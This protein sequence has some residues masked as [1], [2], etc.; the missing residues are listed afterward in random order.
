MTSSFQISR[1]FKFHSCLYLFSFFCRF[2]STAS[3]ERWVKGPSLKS[4]NAKDSR[5][6]DIWRVRR[7]SNVMRGERIG[8]VCDVIFF[9][10]GYNDIQ[11]VNWQYWVFLF[12][13]S[14]FSYV[15]NLASKMEVF[16]PL[17]HPHRNIPTFQARLWKHNR[18]PRTGQGVSVLVLSSEVKRM[19]TMH[20]WYWILLRFQKLDILMSYIDN[21]RIQISNCTFLVIIADPVF[22]SRE[23]VDALREIQS[24]KKLVH[25]N[26]LQLEEI[27]L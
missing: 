24:M 6:R 25:P 26:I 12:Q 17:V 5:M 21:L 14:N 18:Y 4:S 9:S 1:H 8:C 19:L 7:W 22:F 10:T 20:F 2:Q 23:G 13:F 3:L 27:V 11:S 15:H 16:L